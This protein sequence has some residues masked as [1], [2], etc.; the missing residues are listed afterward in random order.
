M[1][2]NKFA[3]VGGDTL[4]GRELR[5]V[6]ESLP[7]SVD[8]KL[9]GAEEGGTVGIVEGAGEPI[10]VSPLDEENLIGAEVVMMAGGAASSRRAWEML[11]LRKDRP[12]VIDLSGSL[13]SVPG[14]Q[15]RAPSVET[16]GFS[17]NR[18]A[19]QVIAHPCAIALAV[20]LRRALAV[21]QIQSA[22]VNA[23]LPASEQGNPGLDELHQQTVSLFGFQSMPK[24][25]FDEQLAFNMLS[26]WGEEAPAGRLA[27]VEKRIREDLLRILP[28]VS[29]T[30]LSLRTVQAPVFH[31][32]SFSVWMKGNAASDPAALAEGLRGDLVDVWEAANGAPNNV[33]TVGDAGIGVGDIRKDAAVPQACWL[34]LTADNL[35]LRASNAIGAARI[36]LI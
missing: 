12:F 6:F 3:I 22:V 19:V 7:G 13:A 27:D 9:I 28:A 8:V 5:E 33:S 1:S 26:V 4:L 24:T 18:S 11:A 17:V 2:N 31:S 20:F 15:L 10:V 34:W 36:W 29:E 14:A 35:R 30:A 16:P 23:F 21:G 25:V 32:L